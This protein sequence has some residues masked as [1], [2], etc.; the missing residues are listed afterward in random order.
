MINKLKNWWVVIFGTV[1][2]VLDTGFDVINPILTYFEIT[3]NWIN[4]IKVIF[5]VYG[6][7]KLKLAL[8]SMDIDKLKEIFSK[9]LEEVKKE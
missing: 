9:K 8:P 6:L 2:L 3:P 5:S 1:L 4:T 7:V